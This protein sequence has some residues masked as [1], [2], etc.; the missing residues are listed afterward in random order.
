M[1][2]RFSLAAQSK[3]RVGKLLCLRGESKA[4]TC[5]FSGYEAGSR[6]SK[7]T[8]DR[9]SLAA[10]VVSLGQGDSPVCDRSSPTLHKRT[11]SEAGNRNVDKWH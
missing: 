4:G 2:V 1:G 5:R 8:C 10:P 7:R 6:A 3:D 11:V 9:F